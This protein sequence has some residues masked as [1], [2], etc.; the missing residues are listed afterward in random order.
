[1]YSTVQG[2]EMSTPLELHRSFLA[3]LVQNLVEIVQSYPP[4][5]YL[6]PIPRMGGRIALA[7]PGRLETLDIFIESRIR[8]FIEGNLDR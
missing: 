5:V 7:A 4:Q 2:E 1:M 6:A 8:Q 3:S